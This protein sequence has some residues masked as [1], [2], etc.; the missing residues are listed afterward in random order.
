MPHQRGMPFADE[1][2]DTEKLNETRDLCF[3]GVCAP[4]FC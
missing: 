1:F 3:F 4:S 2:K